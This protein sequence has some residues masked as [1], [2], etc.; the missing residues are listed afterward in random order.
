MVIS[1][2]CLPQI[3]V[4]LDPLTDLRRPDP[5]YCVHE[6]GIRLLLSKSAAVTSGDLIVSIVGVGIWA[7]VRCF[8]RYWLAF[9]LL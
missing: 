5:S 7:R 6:R 1:S 2:L 3:I 9:G 4:F 8:N